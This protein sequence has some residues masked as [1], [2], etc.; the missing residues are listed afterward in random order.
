MAVLTRSTMGAI[1]PPFLLA[2]GSAGA[3][4]YFGT[5]TRS[6]PVLPGAAADLLRAAIANPFDSSTLLTGEQATAAVLIAAGW[7]VIPM[8]AAVLIFSRQDLASE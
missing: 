7:F 1:L 2:L 8:T 6:L 3:Q 5:G 4:A